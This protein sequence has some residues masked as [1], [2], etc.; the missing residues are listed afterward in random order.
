MTRNGMMTRTR[1]VVCWADV[2]AALWTALVSGQHYLPTPPP[3]SVP[4]PHTF[5]AASRKKYLAPSGGGGGC[6]VSLALRPAWVLAAKK[7][8]T[9]AGATVAA[10]QFILWHQLRWDSR[11]EGGTS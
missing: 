11:T 1:S 6:I 2:G 10:S 3:L 7:T 5:A 8:L 4:R 9:G